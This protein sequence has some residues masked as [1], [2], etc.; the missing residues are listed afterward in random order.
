MTA[1]RLARATLLFIAITA[2]ARNQAGS[3]SIARSIAT[4][5]I[6]SVVTAIAAIAT[7]AIATTASGSIAVTSNFELKDVEE[8]NSKSL[9]QFILFVFQE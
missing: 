9:L 2:I 4:A 5:T 8:S 1:D 6:G 3:R 7:I